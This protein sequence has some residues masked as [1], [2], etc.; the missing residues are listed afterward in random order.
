MTLSSHCHGL[1]IG[2]HDN[3]RCRLT[4]QVMSVHLLLLMLMLHLLKL[5]LLLMAHN[6][7]MSLLSALC[8]PRDLLVRT[9]A[10]RR[11]PEGRIL[12]MRLEHKAL[13][14]HMR[15]SGR[16]G[17]ALMAQGSGLLMMPLNA[18]QRYRCRY[19][20]HRGIGGGDGR[21]NA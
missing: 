1:A 5:K 2:P 3:V 8:V 16:H 15:L 14:N 13:R 7:V 6:R 11:V 12:L 9:C 10:T 19:T 17:H 21:S 18:R 20:A 4:L